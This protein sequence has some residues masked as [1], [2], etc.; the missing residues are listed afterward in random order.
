MKWAHGAI[1]LLFFMQKLVVVMQEDCSNIMSSRMSS[2][3]DSWIITK[4]QLKKS[5]MRDDF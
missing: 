1:P 4:L 2:S 5:L 3:F